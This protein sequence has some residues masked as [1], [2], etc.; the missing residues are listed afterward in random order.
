M[1]TRAEAQSAVEASLRA[2]GMTKRMTPVELLQFCQ[3]MH[4]RLL[5]T[6]KGDRMSDIRQWAERGE[7]TQADE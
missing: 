3:R 1:M 6:S 2:R 4:A 7:S 5:F